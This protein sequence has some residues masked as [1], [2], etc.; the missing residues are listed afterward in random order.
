MFSRKARQELALNWFL[1]QWHEIFEWRERIKEGIGKKSISTSNSFLYF[2]A[3]M[4]WGCGLVEKCLGEQKCQEKNLSRKCFF[5]G[6]CVT[7]VNLLGCFQ[8]SQ[9]SLVLNSNVR[10]GLYSRSVQSQ[11]G[12]WKIIFMKNTSSLVLEVF[13]SYHQEEN[14]AN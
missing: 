6:V 13:C 12:T 2:W 1:I 3:I 8:G 11:S 5:S 14:I 10:L 4:V 9:D 7:L